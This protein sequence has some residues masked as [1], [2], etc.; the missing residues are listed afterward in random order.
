MSLAHKVSSQCAEDKDMDV[1]VIFRVK[2]G[3]RLIPHLKSIITLCTSS[4]RSGSGLAQDALTLMTSTIR[5]MPSF[6]ASNDVG[7]V[8]SCVMELTRS[9]SSAL[10]VRMKDSVEEMAKNLPGGVM[11]TSLLDRWDAKVEVCFPLSP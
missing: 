11:L 2:L 4:L 9:T 1:F 10:D 3:P 8:V 7:E 5:S 6:W